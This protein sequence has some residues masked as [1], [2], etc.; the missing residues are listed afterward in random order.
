MFDIDALIKRLQD[1]NAN[2]TVNIINV[3]DAD[4][5]DDY[6]FVTDFEVGQRVYVCHTRKDGTG[7]IHVKGTVE[8]FGDDDNGEYV[9][10]TGDNGKHY[11]CGLRLDEERLGSKIFQ[12]LD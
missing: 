12:V 7:T 1:T 2:V 6:D 8:S 5:E 10:V 4:V 11:R 9:R 3:T